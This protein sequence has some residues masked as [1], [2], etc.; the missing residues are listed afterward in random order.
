VLVEQLEQ[1]VDKMVG[2]VAVAVSALLLELE[3]AVK[4]MRVVLVNPQLIL[5]AVAVVAL[6]RLAQTVLLE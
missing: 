5:T 3:W 4:E 1:P 2:L 6:V